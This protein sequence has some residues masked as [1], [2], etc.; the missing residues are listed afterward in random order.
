VSKVPMVSIVDDDP[1]SREGIKDLVHSLGYEALAF[2][3]GEQFVTSGRVADTACLITDLQMPGLN[4]FDLHAQL[5]SGGYR[6]P[7]IF[8]TAYPEDRFRSRAFDAGAVGFFEKPLDVEALIECLAKAV[9]SVPDNVGGA[10]GAK[11][12]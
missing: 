6:T 2:S 12:L 4:G 9:A 10:R 1:W 7:V 8:V 5:L 3:S 11:S